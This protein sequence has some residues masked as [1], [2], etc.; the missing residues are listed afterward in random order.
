M[1]LLLFVLF[2]TAL[3]ELDTEHILEYHN[4]FRTTNLTWSETLSNQ[5]QAWADQ[6][7]P[8]HSSY[9]HEN[10]AWGSPYL[11]LHVALTLWGNERFNLEPNGTCREGTICG[12]YLQIVNE[13]NTAVGCAMSTCWDTYN[14]YVCQYE[15]KCTS[16]LKDCLKKC[17]SQK[18]IRKAKRR[19]RRRCKKIY[20]I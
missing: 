6:C 2:G 1:K 19:C 16:E 7:N 5:S 20:K 10:L 15:R 17:N 3:G 12:H 4:Q 8:Y 9:K 13:K 18:R 11:S 14:Y